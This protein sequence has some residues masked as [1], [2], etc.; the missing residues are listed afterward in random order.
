MQQL[1]GTHEASQPVSLLL[2]C[3]HAT[4][5]PTGP[6]RKITTCTKSSTCTGQDNYACVRI[7]S[8][9]GESKQRVFQKVSGHRVQAI[10]TIERYG[11]DGPNTLILHKSHEF[12]F[13]YLD[14]LTS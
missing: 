11:S 1:G 14:L 6:L 8:R 3:T 5:G 12:T 9:R 4:H 2:Q 10:R 13:S 7:V